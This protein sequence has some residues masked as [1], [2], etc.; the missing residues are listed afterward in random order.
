MT[1]G[2]AVE[3][4][5]W[6]GLLDEE[7]LSRFLEEYAA[8]YQQALD[9]RDWQS[10][11]DFVGEWAATAEALS[12]PELRRLLQAED[13]DTSKRLPLDYPV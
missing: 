12:D 4:L 9:T 2:R 7:H 10:L 1:A 13:L 11:D 6:L 8:A 3:E 5:P